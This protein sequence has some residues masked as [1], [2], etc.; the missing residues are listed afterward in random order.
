MQA[1]KMQ[2]KRYGAE[3]MIVSS[4]LLNLAQLYVS[5]GKLAAAEP[6][7]KRAIVICEKQ[8]P[9]HS[10]QLA[11]ALSMYAQLLEKMKRTNEAKQMYE[12]SD[13]LIQGSQR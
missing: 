5:E 3:E 9:P 8:T 7:Y 10:S 2:E 11:V 13:G 1:L 6:L 12:R 4:S